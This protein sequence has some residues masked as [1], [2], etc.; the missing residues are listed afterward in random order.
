MLTIG[1]PVDSFLQPT[2]S[3]VIE[4]VERGR[5]LQEEIWFNSGAD[6]HK[7]S[8]S[9]ENDALKVEN[10]DFNHNAHYD[11]Q[12]R[13]VRVTQGGTSCDFKLRDSNFA[14]LDG[15]ACCGDADTQGRFLVG[16]SRGRLRLHDANGN[17]LHCFEGHFL[18]TNLARFFPSQKVA[19]SSG[20][21]YS[22]KLWDTDSGSLVQ[23]LRHQKGL[24]D[25][26]VM[27]ERGR[28]FVS[29]CVADSSVALYECGSGE[30]VQEYF[31]D[32]L[33]SVALWTARPCQTPSDP[34]GKEFGIDGKQLVVGCNAAA[35]LVDLRSRKKEKCIGGI[36]K[37]LAVK[38]DI[39][40]R[41]G[42]KRIEAY[43][44]RNL[45]EPLF[46]VDISADRLVVN[47]HALG[48]LHGKSAFGLDLA[49][50]T[51]YRLCTDM[52]RNISSTANGLCT[53]GVSVSLFSVNKPV[54]LA[55]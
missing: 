19:L 39:L 33:N 27:I 41:S 45:T 11:K 12:S 21:D 46:D 20:M 44:F 52:P 54:S 30:V 7:F 3:E 8:L 29:L 55:T 23:T 37:A 40:F 50:K 6:F 26:V 36:S 15:L 48:I 51:A 5:V 4:D 25:D 16:D 32:S 47:T 24:V 14:L 28:N 43:D 38:D 1:V 22:I 34:T 53:F 10:F 13:I 9:N 31:F 35:Y 2:S 49:C 17:I 42:S 18:H